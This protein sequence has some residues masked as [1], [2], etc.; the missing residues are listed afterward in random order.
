MKREVLCLSLFCVMAFGATVHA[1]AYTTKPVRVIVP[2]DAGSS[3][4]G[5]ARQVLPTAAK[6]LGQPIVIENEG[7][8]ASI[9]GTVRASKAAPDGYTYL[10]GTVATHAAN[11]NMFKALPYDPVKDFTAVAR[12]AG[13]SLVM[14]VPSTSPAKSVSEFVTLAKGGKTLKYASAGIGTSA[15]LSAELLKLR[16]SINMKHVPYKGGPQ[17]VLDLMRGEVDMMFYSFLSFQP[18]IQSKELRLL[19]VAGVSRTSFMPELPTLKELGFDV[20]VTAWYGVFAPAGTPPEFIAK[21]S[22]ALNKALAD[23]E[24]IKSLTATGTDVYPSKSP[25][26]FGEFQRSEMARYKVMID[27]AGIPKT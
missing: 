18:G 6:H 11:P 10:F 3:A 22:D 1:Q 14:A 20:V 7:G 13:Q 19:G 8:A 25:A 5:I 2:L 24:V 4:D 9:S 17:P 15:H 23:P 16:T 26:E 21:L 12:V 27:A